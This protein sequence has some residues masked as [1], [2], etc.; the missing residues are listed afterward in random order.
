M[1]MT[2]C[3]WPLKPTAERIG[4][5]ADVFVGVCP[6]RA[7]LFLGPFRIAHELP[8]LEFAVNLGDR[9]F[10]SINRDALI[11]ARIAA[12]RRMQRAERAVAKAQY[13][14]AL[15][16]GLYLMAKKFHTYRQLLQR[17]QP[18]T[19]ANRRCGRL[20]SLAIRHRPYPKCLSTFR[21]PL[22]IALLPIPGQMPVNTDEVAQ[23]ALLDR[24]ANTDVKRV[25]PR[26][27]YT[28]NLHAVLLARC[29]QLIY[30]LRLYIG[31]FF[32]NH[33]LAR[34]RRLYAHLCV[35]TR[36]RCYVDN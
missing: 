33:M 22:V 25:Q 2:I 5:T 13:G 3:V 4:R 27:K 34:C 9:T 18:A 6:G 15:V 11:V 30:A 1:S 20:D 35:H 24:V 28:G 26:L 8:S 36:R 10:R 19:A 17:V 12:G 14:Y 31:W 7:S 21:G 29:N 23:P 16:F 32:D